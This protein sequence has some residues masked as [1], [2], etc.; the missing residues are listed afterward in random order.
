M[1]QDSTSDILESISKYIADSGQII[2]DMYGNSSSEQEAAQIWSEEELIFLKEN[3]KYFEEMACIASKA[4]T[5]G[6]LQLP[7]KPKRKMEDLFKEKAG[8]KKKR[9][10][11]LSNPRDLHM[12]LISYQTDINSAVLRE[13]F[14]NDA[15]FNLIDER[16]VV[17]SLQKAVKNLKKQNAQILLIHIQFGQFL[18][19]C[20]EWQDGERKAGRVK[21]TWAQWL[22]EKGG[23]SEIH[24]RNL[25]AV[26]K[27]L[28]PFPQFLT[29]GLPIDFIR[30]KLKQIENMLQ[31]EE[32]RLYWAQPVVTHAR[33]AELHQSQ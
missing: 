20:K 3:Q 7:K 21:K 23:Y 26:A 1:S 14:S 15:F 12:Y 5:E 4:Q 30:R 9:G 11:D 16:V 2:K 25:R 33:T 31:I 29:V 19:L 18:I 24:A 13:A 10:V 22:K 6:P 27:S 8:T 32:F 17:E 28:F